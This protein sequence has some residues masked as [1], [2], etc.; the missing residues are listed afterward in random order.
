MYREHAP[1]IA[2][3]MR[4]N[5]FQF[6]RGCMF[7]ICSIRQPVLKVPDQLDALYNEEGENPLF[8]HKLDAWAYLSANGEAVFRDVYAAK[9]IPAA[10]LILCRVPGL[11]I[12]KA[13]FVLQLAG[14][15]VACLDSRNITREGRNP[16][17]YRS[18]GGKTKTGKAWERKIARYCA[19]VSGKAAEYWDAWC[20]DVAN[21]YKRTPEDISAL[22][23]AICAPRQFD[24][25]ETF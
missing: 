17:A 3:Y 11:G 18:D 12:V 16:R 1:V 14:F 6:V 8:G 2:A 5:A 22:H 7:A 20:I 15:D 23:L 9:D 4:E 25:A 19:E 24:L 21:A 10:I 13:A